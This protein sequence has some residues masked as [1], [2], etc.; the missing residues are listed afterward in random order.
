MDKIKVFLGRS[1][2]PLV[3]VLIIA[4]LGT[5]ITSSILLSLQGDP[6]Q[7]DKEVEFIRSDSLVSS[8][9]EKEYTEINDFLEYANYC[10]V[11]E[12]C[13]ILQITP[14]NTKLGCFRFV[15]KT[16]NQYETNSKIRSYIEK[17]ELAAEETCAIPVNAMCSYYKCVESPI[18]TLLRKDFLYPYSL[19]WI[20]YNEWTEGSINF[21][22]TSVLL[23]A[24]GGSQNFLT[25]GG[26]T[27]Y[28]PYINLENEFRVIT[29]LLK[30]QNAD[31]EYNNTLPINIRRITNEEG[32]KVTPNYPDSH[33]YISISPNATLYDQQFIFVVPKDE[34]EFSFTTGGASNIHFNIKI[35]SDTLEITKF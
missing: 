34:T 27:Y 13:K 17:C 9:C 24:V 3:A 30:I 35:L 23:E 22:I 12:D 18:A 16:F 5:I 4:L 6:F 8:E 21:S 31:K 33:S 19:S 14:A 25:F 10:D 29:F 1:I 2:S 20:E 28:P 32:D 15:N 7:R 11:N 26:G